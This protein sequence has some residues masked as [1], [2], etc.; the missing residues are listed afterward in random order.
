MSPFEVFYGRKS[1]RELNM[2]RAG[3]D[4][5]PEDIE[6][7][8][9]CLPEGKMFEEDVLFAEGNEEDIRRHM[10]KLQDVRS[11]AEKN[12]KK[13]STYMVKRNMR[14]N[15]PSSYEV[16]E[17]IFLRVREK[18]SGVTRGGKPLH[19]PLVYHGEIIDVDHENFH[20]KVKY[21]DSSSEFIDYVSVNN[22]TSLTRAQ[23]QEKQRQ[24]RGQ[25]KRKLSCMCKDVNC[26]RKPAFDCR[27][28]MN[29]VCCE[30][31]G[32]KCHHH[33][34][35]HNT[36]QPFTTDLQEPSTSGQAS[37]LSQ[38]PTS[39][40]LSTCRYDL[41][42]SKALGKIFGDFS[43]EFR[44]MTMKLS[45]EKNQRNLDRNIQNAG[46]EYAEQRTPGDGNCMFHALA[47]Q[48]ERTTHIKITH[49]Q[50]RAQVVE[51][52]HKNRNTIDGTHMQAWILNGEWD[53]YL[54]DMARDGEW[55]DEIILKL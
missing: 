11:K 7:E 8:M 23:E 18:K 47:A 10:E 30:N 31:Q 1:N 25:I 9:E 33:G 39:R 13:S 46:L 24:A 38:N 4:T 55:G 32:K 36:E 41:S 44:L 14:K 35:G 43:R 42:S 37:T 28:K 22:I 2:L 12:E 29:A 16:G 54:S 26:K 5:T 15:P 49:D 48:L 17:K 20:Y 3:Q 51:H 6:V 52:L 19:K 50:L 21:F 45:S 53:R 40:D 34:A 27:F